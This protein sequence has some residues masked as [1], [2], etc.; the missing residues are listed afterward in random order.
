MI[1][2]LGDHFL[3]QPFEG[4]KFENMTSHLT[5]YSKKFL[6]KPPANVDAMPKYSNS[7][8][9][10]KTHIF[11]VKDTKPVPKNITDKIIIALIDFTHPK[12][13]SV[14]GKK[15]DLDEYMKNNEH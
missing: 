9:V 4:G 2:F 15:I 5:Y 10:F 3:M 8:R 1:L 7:F 13:E 14:I 12:S 6:F 11:R